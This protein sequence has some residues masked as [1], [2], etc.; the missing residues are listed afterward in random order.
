MSDIEKRL[1]AIEERNSRVELDKAWETSWL[2]RVSLALMTYITVLLFL[3]TID[4]ERPAINAL[5]PTGGFLLS[6][7]TMGWLRS[8]WQRS[9]N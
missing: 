5:V 3:M 2:R 8:T 4:N 1:N 6:T 9:R 7:L